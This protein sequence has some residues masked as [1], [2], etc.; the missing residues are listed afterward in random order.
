MI[1][2]FLTSFFSSLGISL[3]SLP[4]LGSL[5]VVGSFLTSDRRLKSDVVAVSWSR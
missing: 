2:T 4:S 5:P 3:P 1:P